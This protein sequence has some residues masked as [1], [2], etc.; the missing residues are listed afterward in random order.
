MYFAAVHVHKLFCDICITFLWN[1]SQILVILC[2]EKD[3]CY[4]KGCLNVCYCSSDRRWK[5]RQLTFKRLHAENNLVQNILCKYLFICIWVNK[6]GHEL[7]YSVRLSYF[8]FVCIFLK[9]NLLLLVSAFHSQWVTLNWRWRRTLLQLCA[10]ILCIQV[11]K[12]ILVEYHSKIM[13]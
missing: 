4:F 7:R 6:W 9:C 1:Y 3:L 13:I 5:S 10:Y 2:T 12:I 11:K 8:A